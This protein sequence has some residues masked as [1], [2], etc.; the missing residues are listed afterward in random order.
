MG[1]SLAK[2]RWNGIM[3]ETEVAF[4]SVG[5]PDRQQ[6]PLIRIN[7]RFFICCAL[8]AAMFQ[9]LLAEGRETEFIPASTPRRALGA[10]LLRAEPLR[11]EP[12]R[13]RIQ[14][15]APSVAP[16]ADTVTW[17]LTAKDYTKYHVSRWERFETEFGITEPEQSLVLRSVQTAKYN[18]DR[19]LFAANEFSHNVSSATEFEVDHGRL[20]HV[21]AA[22][23]QSREDMANP[24]T[25][26]SENMR[27]GLELN[28]A[29]G[30]PYVG[31][32]LVIP[33][34]N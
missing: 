28:L 5:T 14:P 11:A 1:R 13:F 27:L 6:L 30:R 18:L 4:S 25:T 29:Q 24:P 2:R 31:V 19:F 33:F 9:L 8:G 26:I 32:K 3:N 7:R 20:Y 17:Q 34:G 23:R 21:S 15:V 10:N 16:S 12:L 22:M